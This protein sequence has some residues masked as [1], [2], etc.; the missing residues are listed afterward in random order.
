MSVTDHGS[1][2][3]LQHNN[4]YI[5]ASTDHFLGY[6][7]LDR[8]SVRHLT[9]FHLGMRYRIRTFTVTV[10]PR[11]YSLKDKVKMGLNSELKNQVNNVPCKSLASR[12]TPRGGPAWN[13][14]LKKGL[15][16]THY[17]M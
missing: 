3:T 15:T 13:L 7:L 2:L 11:E 10:I 1:S 8:S 16:N 9:Q 6:V 14:V 4:T 17:Y 12:T 5:E